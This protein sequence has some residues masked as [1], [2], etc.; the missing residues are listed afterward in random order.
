MLGV[1]ELDEIS[2]NL[3]AYNDIKEEIVIKTI[4]QQYFFTNII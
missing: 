2:R 3:K 1:Q 4:I